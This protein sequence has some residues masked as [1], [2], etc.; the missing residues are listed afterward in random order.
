MPVNVFN[1]GSVTIQVGVNSGSPISVPGTG[2]TQ[3]WA[4]QQPNSSPLSFSDGYPAPN[5]FGSMGMNQ[6]LVMANGSPLGSPLPISIPQSSPVFSLQLYIFVSG[7][8]VWWT[9]LNSGQVIGS[10]QG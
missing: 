10:G 3:N 6:V 5:V 8:S 4:P 9:L 2:P 1:A 7:S